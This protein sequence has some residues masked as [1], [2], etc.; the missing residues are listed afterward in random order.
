MNID[1]RG[2]C[3]LVCGASKGIGRA[4]SLELAHLGADVLIAARSEMILR[5]LVTELPQT[6]GQEHGYLTLDFQDRETVT[7]TVTKV[8]AAKPVHILINNTGG[9][10]AGP[11]TDASAEAFESAFG[12]HLLCNHLL[13]QLTLPGMREAGY[14]R[15]INVISTSVKQPIKGLGVSNTIRAAVGNWAKTLAGEVAADGITVNNIL[16]GATATDRLEEIIHA[17]AKKQGIE[18]EAVRQKMRAGVPMGRF[19]EPAEIAAAAGFLASPAASYITGTNIV[20]DGGRTG[21]L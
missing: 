10:A 7:E 2:K 4:I 3:A 19:A 15:I 1:L 6:D 5:Q 21:C 17:R 14:G 20:V 9:P 13:A 11:V 8:V 16:P 12:Q 18:P